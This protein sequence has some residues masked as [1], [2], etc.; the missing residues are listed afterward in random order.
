VEIFVCVKSVPESD[1]I[2]FDEET[3]NLR[4]EGV[5]SVINPS[6]LVSLEAGLR[7]AE[8]YGGRVSAI[9]MG[10]PS[11]EA[12][13]RTALAMGA[14]R[15]FLLCASLFAGAD[16]PATAYALSAFF[17]SLP[18]FDIIFCGKHSADGDTGQTGAM[19]AEK[20]GIPHACGVCAPVQRDQDGVLARQRMDHHIL[21]TR[22]PLPCLVIME[23]DAFYPR[24]ATLAGILR[25]R[26]QE[27]IRPDPKDIS[28]LDPLLCGGKGSA[29]RVKKIFVPKHSRMGRMLS[30]DE[31]E[32]LRPV[33]VRG[34]SPRD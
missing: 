17:S 27:I 12:G 28:G 21:T 30:E 23:N 13:L 15:A 24:N 10:P 7:W 5:G 19:I 31:L 8:A 3:G 14:E 2:S 4:R 34:G 22:L 33:L 25:A 9:S 20:L 18:N 16:V 6:D 32:V 26:R 11:A 1:T 29:T